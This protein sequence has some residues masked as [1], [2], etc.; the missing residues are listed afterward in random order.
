MPKK[1]KRPIYLSEFGGYCYAV[2]GHLYD[3]NKSYGYKNFSSLEEFRR[4]FV[5]LYREQIIPNVKNGLCASIYTQVSDVEEEINGIM[6]YDRK[7]TKL[8]PEDTLPIAK[9]LRIK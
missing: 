9:D 4:A 6:T 8:S 1:S 3:E 2:K 7:I 5:A